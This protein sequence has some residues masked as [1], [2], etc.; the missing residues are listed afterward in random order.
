MAV[1]P[2]LALE[3]EF[4]AGTW[5]AVTGDLVELSTRRGRNAESGA[6]ETGQLVI[7]LRNDDR[8]Y[9]PDHAT[10]P[11]Y[12]NL[13][14]NRRVRFQATYGGTT[15]PVFFGYVDRIDQNYG[16]PNDATAELSVSDY[17]KILNRA[18][19]PTSVY[20]AE[21]EDDNP[22]AWWRLDE[23][24]GAAR[25]A[26]SS[27]GE[28]HL[29]AAGAVGFGA[30]GLAVRDPGS[31]VELPGTVTDSLY[32][33]FATIPVTAPPLTLECLYRRTAPG[34][35]GGIMGVYGPSARGALWLTTTTG[36]VIILAAATP[37]VG[38]GSAV[39]A[40]GVTT[41]VDVN[42]L[43][44][45]HVVGKWRATG[46]LEIWVDGVNRT[47]GTPT[48]APAAFAPGG[49]LFVGGVPYVIETADAASFQHGAVYN[50]DLTSPRITAHNAAAR[51]PWKGDETGG[52]LNGI[53]TLAGVASGAGARNIDVGNTYLQATDLGGSALGYAQKIEETELGWL[54]I[55]RD[56]RVRFI[57]REAGVTGAYATSKATLADA[58]AGGG[59]P[60]RATSATVEEANLVTRATV[61][62][63][64][65]VAVTYLD[66]AAAAEFQ[67][68]D[69]THEGL[70]HDDDDYSRSY[71]EWIVNTRKRP[72]TRVGAI[73]LVPPA[74]PAAIYPAILGLE[75]ADRVT[76]R[77]K[78]QNVGAVVETAMRVEAI[79]HVVSEGVWRTT[80]QLSP[81]HRAGGVPVFVWDSTTWD[82]HVWG[83]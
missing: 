8:R 30:E 77:R 54:F 66:A 21:V 6:F 71:A 33:H 52:R 47:S 7:T 44:V 38:G 9:D 59:I 78:P 25:A 40:V 79:S 31:S 5:T 67:I 62:R 73:S 34:T 46:A 41:G 15:Y 27:G 20:A 55:A 61:S 72:T 29:V 75:L 23:P 12:G 63:E 16:G 18:E 26:D 39:S 68:V 65:S 81:F 10:G 19:L 4:T 42:D 36:G 1:L 2:T 43:A 83:V 53:L 60:Y 80:L 35:D 82:N 50:Y 64:G 37:G 11:Y 13:R 69:E 57:A 3:I 70:L 45:H 24:S 58:D 74:D 48:L 28:Y 56:G 32:G 76:L 49:H 22:V 17:F 51:T 14:P